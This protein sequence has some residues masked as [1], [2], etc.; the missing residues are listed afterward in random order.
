MHNVNLGLLQISNGS[1]LLLGSKHFVPACGQSEAHPHLLRFLWRVELGRKPAGGLQGLPRVED[2]QEASH[3]PKDF[4]AR[5]CALGSFA[6]FAGIVGSLPFW[7]SQ[8]FR[9]TGQ[10]LKQGGAQAKMTHKAYNGRLIVEWLS[11]LTQLA[12]DEQSFTSWL[13]SKTPSQT[14]GRWLQSR[15]RDGHQPFPT[16]AKLPF[17]R[18]C[19]PL[20]WKLSKGFRFQGQQHAGGLDWSS[21]S[22]DT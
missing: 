22:H 5:I 8:R 19:L 3:Q 21:A 10:V 4:P 11:E 1:S 17:Q 7:K 12:C 13:A 20:G 14:F 18:T 6:T 2:I 9:Q 16:D 15:V